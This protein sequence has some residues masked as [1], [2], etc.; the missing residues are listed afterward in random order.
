MPVV[1]PRVAGAC[2]MNHMTI[3]RIDAANDQVVKKIY[4]ISTKLKLIYIRSTSVNC[5]EQIMAS[6]STFICHK[7]KLKEKDGPHRLPSS[8]WEGEP[9]NT[10]T[11]L[12]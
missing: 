11:T 1:M 7:I 4:L 3:S 8:L 9:N 5:V 2:T 10:F 6:T 12:W